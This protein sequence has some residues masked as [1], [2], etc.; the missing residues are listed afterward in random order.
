M[1]GSRNNQYSEDQRILKEE[2]KAF[3]T[4]TKYGLM[5]PK[6]DPLVQMQ[7]FLKMQNAY[8]GL[9]SEKTS[10]ISPRAIV[11]YL[12]YR[13]MLDRMVNKNQPSPLPS[14]MDPFVEYFKRGNNRGNNTI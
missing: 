12:V 9:F 2:P 7:N 13:K 14:G 8:P 6:L 1:L 11:S 10:L 5:D 3:Y 4:E